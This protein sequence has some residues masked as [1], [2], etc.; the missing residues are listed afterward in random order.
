MFAEYKSAYTP[1]ERT[2]LNNLGLENIFLDSM[3]P[4]I[5]FRAAAERC[6]VNDSQG[7]NIDIFREIYKKVVVEGSMYRNTPEYNALWDQMSLEI[8]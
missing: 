5:A 4:M 1:Q 2:F 3:N 6:F 8:P 7:G